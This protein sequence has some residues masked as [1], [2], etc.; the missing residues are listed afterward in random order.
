MLFVHHQDAESREWR[1]DGGPRPHHDVRLSAPHAAP[2]VE[3]L[4]TLE[5]AV[6]N[7]HPAAEACQETL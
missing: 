1:E 7:R 6:E 2:G 3:A 4:P 5:A